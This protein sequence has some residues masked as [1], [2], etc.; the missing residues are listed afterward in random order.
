L[1]DDDDNGSDDDSTD[2]VPSSSIQ[3][4]D[5]ALSLSNDLLLFLLEKGEETAVEDQQ[6]VI[7]ALQEAK[8]M[9][10]AKQTTLHDFM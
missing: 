6:R 3:S 5:A 8:L 4:F 9:S 7:S 1:D 10:K 2:E